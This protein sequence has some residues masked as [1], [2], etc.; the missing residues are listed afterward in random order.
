MYSLFAKHTK[1][2]KKIFFQ[3]MRVGGVR[4]LKIY[5]GNKL[6]WVFKFFFFF[7]SLNRSTRR[8]L[9]TH[10]FFS[11]GICQN[12]RRSRFENRLKKR[13]NIYE[14]CINVCVLIV[15][16]QKKITALSRHD[17][18]YILL[19]IVVNYNRRP[20]VKIKFVITRPLYERARR[21]REMRFTQREI[22]PSSSSS[23]YFFTYRA[24]SYQN[25]KSVL[26]WIRI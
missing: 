18:F 15:R 20:F 3:F 8:F 24:E 21:V 17:T 11:R 22:A 6:L 16:R 13:K 9:V 5:K 19:F 4:I 12:V 10:N 14:N 2:K 7:C 23:S 1:K 25:Q 26:L